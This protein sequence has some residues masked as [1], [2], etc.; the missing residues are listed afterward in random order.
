MPPGTRF[1]QAGRRLTSCLRAEVTRWPGA[2]TSSS[3]CSPPGL[4]RHDIS[5]HG[6]KI[7][8]VRALLVKGKEVARRPAMGISAIRTTA[9]IRRSS[10]TPTSLYAPRMPAGT[11]SSSSTRTLPFRN[12]RDL[13]GR[14]AAAAARATPM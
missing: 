11:P 5:C 4:T 3:C 1:I 13:S 2:R 10:P 12:S 14:T 9:K 6:E 8:D 7:L